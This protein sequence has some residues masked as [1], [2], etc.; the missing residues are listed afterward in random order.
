[1]GEAQYMGKGKNETIMGDVQVM[2][3]VEIEVDQ[4]H[5]QWDV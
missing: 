4:G 5:G 1:M 2:R 3:Q